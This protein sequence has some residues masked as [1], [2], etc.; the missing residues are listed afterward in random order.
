MA[1][2]TGRGERQSEAAPTPDCAQQ[3]EKGTGRWQKMPK[4]LRDG[5]Q[6]AVVYTMSMEEGLC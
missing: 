3:H 5:K 4:S 1:F 2:A 6:T